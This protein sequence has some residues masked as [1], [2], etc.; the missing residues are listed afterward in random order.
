MAKA[1]YNGEKNSKERSMQKLLDAV[2]T[3][4]K[5]KGYTG[6]SSVNV[7][8]A[9]GLNRML[10]NM[11]FGSLD[12]LVETYVRGKDYWVA[13]AGNARELME[14][15]KN[16]DTRE[17][18]EALLINQLSYFHK[19]E[20]M[21]KIVL[22]QLSE[23]SEIMFE[24]AEEREKLGETFF[25]SA[26]PYFANTD[27]DLRAVAGLLVGGIYYMVLHAKSNDS[28]FCQ[29]DVNSPE[30]LERIKNAIKQILKDTY[31]KAEKYK[32]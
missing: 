20:E 27:V 21:Q 31:A 19:E 22:W 28:L 23:R 9:A 7:G 10:I 11:Y 16:K 5:T 26:D 6:L 2:G 30:G 29:I 4:I 17:I 13:A 25:N 1:T 18:L 32:R 12:N 24:I 8:K 15:K 3:I 14:E